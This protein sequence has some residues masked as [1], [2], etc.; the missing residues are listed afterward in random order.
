MASGVPQGHP[1]NRFKP[2]PPRPSATQTKVSRCCS[3]GDEILTSSKA[4]INNYLR[5]VTQAAEGKGQFSKT[6]H[7]SLSPLHLDQAQGFQSKH[8]K[9]FGSL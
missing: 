9:V 1:F 8:T 3:P 6:S 2:L 5:K 4:N 7:K